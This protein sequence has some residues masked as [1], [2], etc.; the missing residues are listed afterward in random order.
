MLDEAKKRQ[1][2]RPLRSFTIDAGKVSSWISTIRKDEEISAQDKK[3]LLESLR[4]LDVFNY[5]V[6]ATLALL[7]KEMQKDMPE[8]ERLKAMRS[9]LLRADNS[10]HGWNAALGFA[11]TALSSGDYAEPPLC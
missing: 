3:S 5:S 4:D 9:A 11:Q 10:S 8:I 1:D 7:E 6:F 2:Q